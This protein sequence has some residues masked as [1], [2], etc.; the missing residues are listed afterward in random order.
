MPPLLV[1]TPPAPQKVRV[2]WDT[3]LRGQGE[4]RK[5]SAA[6]W[7]CFEELVLTTILPTYEDTCSLPLVLGPL[8]SRPTESMIKLRRSAQHSG[9]RS[10]G[11]GPRPALF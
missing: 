3:E 4:F 7:P 8:L 11:A 6:T 1:R 10:G 9:G 2:I 5:E